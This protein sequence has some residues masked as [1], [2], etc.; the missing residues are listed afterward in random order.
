M[1]AKRLFWTLNVAC[2]AGAIRFSPHRGRVVVVG[3]KED[4]TGSSRNW[5]TE[6]TRLLGA[7]LARS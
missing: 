3:G 2:P 6:G 7:T 4:D 5:S 1:I